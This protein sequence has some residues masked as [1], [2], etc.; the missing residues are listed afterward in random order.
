MSETKHK[1]SLRRRFLLLADSRGAVAVTAAILLVTLFSITAL[2][3][4]IGQAVVAKN[5]LQNVADAA[6]LAGARVLGTTYQS[7]TPD[8]QRAYTLTD[9]SPIHASVLAVAS[10]NKARGVPISINISDISIGTWD[11]PTKILTVTNVGP[12]AVRVTARRD[13]AAN[14]PITT[15]I[16]GIMGVSSLSVTARATAALTGTGTVLPGELDATF[17]ISDEWFNDP[18][19]CN[20]PVQFAP[21]NDSLGCA[22]WHTFNQS[23]ANANTLRNILLGLTDG[24]FEAP[25]L[26]IMDT[27]EFIGGTVASAFPYLNALFDAKKE[28]VGESAENPS[29]WCWNIDVAVYDD[30][31]CANPQ[32]DMT[33][34]G[35]AAA[36]ITN[37]QIAP[38]DEK[39]IDALVTCGEY[40]DAR[41]GG[42]SFG[43]R[44]SIPGLVE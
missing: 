29:G 11:S 24:T 38:E 23:P 36:C 26:S 32:G 16:A 21:T 3:L 15:W 41:G 10:Q 12:D 22:G 19:S 6:A 20:Q 4:D 2:S 28:W 31:G 44:G 39:Q 1:H 7:L 27:L 35:F 42:G 33:I 43:T 5:E 18:I 34:V 17:A 30:V 37:V 40:L 25:A 9:P 13:S 8:E 14:G